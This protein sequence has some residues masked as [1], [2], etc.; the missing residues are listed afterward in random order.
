MSDER[1]AAALYISHTSAGRTSDCKAG[2]GTTP[3]LP[4]GGDRCLSPNYRSCTHRPPAGEFR[5][6][7]EGIGG[8][9]LPPEV[10]PSTRVARI[11]RQVRQEKLWRILPGV[12]GQMWSKC[13]STY[14]ALRSGT[15]RTRL[16]SPSGRHSPC[17]IVVSE[18]GA[19]FY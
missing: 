14:I 19:G 5:E 1:K 2:L 11:S 6:E 17:T 8:T 12:T 9:T 4:V 7:S 15:K 3:I 16:S 18:G 13:A 10:H